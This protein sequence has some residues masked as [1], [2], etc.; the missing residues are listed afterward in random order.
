M[1]STSRFNP[2]IAKNAKSNASESIYA[3]QTEYAT[4]Q[5][6]WTETVR[7]GAPALTR[8]RAND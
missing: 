8:F 7:E 4:G 5:R 6:C 3:Y 2:A 1:R